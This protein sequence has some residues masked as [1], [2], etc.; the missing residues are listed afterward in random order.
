MVMSRVLSFWEVEKMIKRIVSFLLCMSIL[1]SVSPQ[2]AFADPGD[3]NMEG[4]GGGMGSGTGSN[5]WHEGEDGARVTVIKASDKSIVSKSIDLTNYNESNVFVHFGK[6]SKIKYKNGASLTPHFETNSY[7][8][9]KPD[10]P[11]PRI[12]SNGGNAN[13]S[14]I[15][16]Y[17]CSELILRKIAGLIGADYEKL[18]NGNYKL[19]IEPIAFV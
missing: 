16:H 3:G 13:I 17:F 19:L 8:A 12:I 10:S 1:F 15:K 9:S 5:F 6:N 2:F 4:G 14:A 11:M 7:I 18:I